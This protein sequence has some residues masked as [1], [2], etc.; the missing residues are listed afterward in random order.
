LVTTETAEPTTAAATVPEVQPWRLFGVQVRAVRRLSP[1][2]VRLTFTGPD[3]DRFADPGLD[4]RIK[5]V[6]PA[7][8]RDGFD[9]VPMDRGWAGLYEL[10]DEIRPRIRTYTTRALRPDVRE[11]D[12][13]LVLHGDGG[14]ASRF[15]GSAAPG[16]VVAFLGPNA[17]YDG[18]PG[19][20]EFRCPEG[21]PVLLVGDETALP[22]IARIL[23]ELP[24]GTTGEAVV[25]VPVGGDRLE[26]RRP[27]GVRLTW[28]PRDEAGLDP[29]EPA[30]SLL[31]AA[32]VEALARTWPRLIGAAHT[33]EDVPETDEDQP[34]DVPQAV[35]GEELYA[36]MAGESGA[37]TRLRR[38][39][40]RDLGI[41]RTT[42]AFMGYWKHGRVLD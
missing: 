9:G 41:D 15:A 32:V 35:V 28:L 4:Q 26:L 33:G 14:P 8:G 2:Y 30:G 39:L 12:V 42:I 20:L 16:D 5:L 17:D 11:L 13:D 38:Y 6:L 27:A 40:V 25:E 7:P 3:L 29:H 22:A 1:S 31:Q 21:V 19:G 37:I 10:P 24:A 34:W 36:W 23:E 18:D